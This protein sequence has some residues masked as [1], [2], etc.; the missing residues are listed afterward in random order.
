[1]LSVASASGSGMS[2]F[3]KLDFMQLAIRAELVS[4]RI[5]ANPFER[6]P[7]SADPHVSHGANG[8]TWRPSSSQCVCRC[9][10]ASRT[11]RQLKRYDYMARQSST[12]L[13]NHP[14]P[15]ELRATT[16]SEFASNLK[17]R[18]PHS[19]TVSVQPILARSLALQA[20]SLVALT[21]KSPHVRL[22]TRTRGRRAGR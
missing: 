19:E 21:M 14:R 16:R 20:G 8:Y 2:R 11:T 13:S 17:Q 15:S 9:L 1:M 18:R 5:Q 10:T 12:R 4:L 3:R 22:C 6:L 7:V